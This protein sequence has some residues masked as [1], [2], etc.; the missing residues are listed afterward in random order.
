ME[1]LRI[2]IADKDAGFRKQLKDILKV[3][4][5]TLVGETEDSISAL[6][7]IR[8]LEPDVVLVSMELPP[9]G[10]LE[11]AKIIEEGRLASILMI[12]EY[13]EKDIVFKAN[14]K[15]TIPVLIK[16]F[17]DVNLLSL[18]EYSYSAF[19]KV[20]ELEREI[21]KLKTG[22]E[23]RKAVEKAKG[24]LMKLQGLSEE[25]AFKR[26]Q[27]QSMRKRTSMKNIAEAIIMTYELSDRT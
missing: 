11:L 24:I 1:K 3:A 26:I 23:A 15:S 22:L 20:I 5:H 4:G 27:Q 12:V 9:A 8:S 25:E 10:G 16:P 19:N 6:R 2:I 14:E 7:M 17:D 18:L 21:S 13:A